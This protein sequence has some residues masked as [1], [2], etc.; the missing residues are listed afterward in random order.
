M[1][2]SDFIAEYLKGQGIETVFDFTGGM[3]TSLEDSISRLPGIECMPVRH[4]QA[5]GFAAEGYARITRNF[6]VAIATSGPGATNMIT[7]IGSCYFDSTPALFITGQVN[8]KDLRASKDVRQNGFQELD[9]VEMVK[10]VTKYAKQVLDSQ[11]LLYELEKAIFLMKSDRPGPVLLDLPFN[12]QFADMAS[13]PSRKFIGSKEHEALL[14]QASIS[15]A[16]PEGLLK[17]MESA[18]APIVIFGN[19]IKSSDAGGKLQKFLKSNSLPSVSSLLGLGEIAAGFDHYLGFIGSYGNRTAN[20]ALANAD[21]IIVLG[22][23][24]DLRQTGNPGMFAKKAKIFHVDIDEFSR[25]DIFQDYVFLH[26]DLN[27]FFASTEGAAISGK[28]DWLEFLASLKG[29]IAEEYKEEKSYCNPNVFFEN[30]SALAP[31]DSIVV[32][33]VGQNQMWLAQ[34]WKVKGGQA[35]LF[36]GGMGAMG[37]SLPTAIG[38]YY[39]GKTR[40]V[41]SFMGDGGLQMNMQELET[42]K[43]NGLPIKIIV[44]N[45]KSLGMVREFQDVWFDRNHQSTV[46]GYSCPDLQKLAGAFGIEY[47][48]IVASDDSEAF[49]D[50][51]KRDGPVLVEVLVSPESALLP[52]LVYGESIE[53]QAPFLSEGK[54]QQLA[55]LKGRFLS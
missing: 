36:S 37:F 49:D 39:A 40:P 27:D 9:V 55:E 6:G 14:K 38:A 8:S 46:I 1:R 19:G 32:G 48:R 24:L 10:G 7:A 18:K 51:I 21:L 30:F 25:K 4:E 17:M 5:A 22:S 33:D 28:A 31:C 3:I 35:L 50:V 23:R 29:I 42:V 16:D 12:V 15:E 2:Y 20:I 26:A 54:K 44:L 45:N 41:F 53:N 13:V 11:D 43:H 34:S 52:K 47:V